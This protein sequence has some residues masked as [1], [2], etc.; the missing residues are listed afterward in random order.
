MRAR[1][2]RKKQ[3]CGLPLGKGAHDLGVVHDESRGDAGNLEELANKF[4]KETGG[5]PGGRA[6][7]LVLDAKLVQELA[8]L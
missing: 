4:V 8:G 3:T 6:I 1:I 5:G 2:K 7:D